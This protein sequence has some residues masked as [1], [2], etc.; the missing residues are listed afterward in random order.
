[1]SEPIEPSRSC[2][3]ISVP[4]DNIGARVPERGSVLHALGQLFDDLESQLDAGAQ[5]D[6]ELDLAL[7]EERLRLGR[8]CAARPARRHGDAPSATTP[9][10]H[11]RSSSAA[12]VLDVRPLAFGRDWIARAS[13]RRLLG[14][15][16]ASCRS[17]RSRPC[18]RPGPARARASSPRPTSTARR[19]PNASDCRSC[20][21]TCAAAARAVD[22]VPPTTAGA[23]H[24]STA[25]GATTSTSRCTTAERR[26]ATPRCGASASCR[27]RRILLVWCS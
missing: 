25:W 20:C 2:Q 27:W 15:G 6:E 16:S 12:R 7:E 23:R 19:S 14:G 11:P 4:V 9:R 18:C 24:A 3:A 17:R 22:L 13:P 1:M 8:L 5:R 10:A 26:G 21:A